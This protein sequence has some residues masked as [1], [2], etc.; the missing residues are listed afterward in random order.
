MPGNDDCNLTGSSKRSIVHKLVDPR[1]LGTLR[2]LGH[3]CAEAIGPM[4]GRESQPSLHTPSKDGAYLITNALCRQT[5]SESE[6]LGGQNPCSAHHPFE[7]CEFGSQ[8]PKQGGGHS[9]LV[10]LYSPLRS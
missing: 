8:P 9:I 6:L 5:R 4:L 3:R 10:A 2:D 1:A 7:H